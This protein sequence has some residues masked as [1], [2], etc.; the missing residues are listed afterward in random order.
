MNISRTVISLIQKYKIFVLCLSEVRK[1][2]NLIDYEL[3]IR[4]L[5]FEAIKD[6]LEQF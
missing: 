5:F 1:Q 2:S 3:I 6:C 4:L